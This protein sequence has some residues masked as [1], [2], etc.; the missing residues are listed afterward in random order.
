[1]LDKVRDGAQWI[2]ARLHDCQLQ[3][4]LIENEGHPVV[5][6]CS[7][8]PG[9]AS[10]VPTLLFYGHYDVQ[11]P[12]PLQKWTSPPFEPTIRGQSIYAR[13]ASDDNGQVCCFLEAVSA[14]MRV[15]G[16]LPCRV[17]VLIEGEEECGSIHL[18]RVIEAHKQE[19]KA[20]IVL[21]SDTT[22]WNRD[23]VAITYGLRGLLYFD[24]Q[25]HN[26]KRDLHSGMFGGILANPAT[27]LTQVLGQLS[28]AQYRITIPH[29]YDDVLEV[30]ETERR[31]WSR[32]GFDE[33]HDCLSTIGV[34]T[35]FGEAGYTTLERK[36]TRPTC[37]ICGLYG[38]YGGSGA[39]TVIPSFAGAKV[40][41]R[42]AGKQDPVKISGDFEHWLRSHGVRGCRWQI[43]QLGAADPVL[44][45]DDSPYMDAAKKAV[46]QTSGKP[47]VLVHD[48]ATIP[49]VADFKK[50]LG[51]DSLLIGFGQTDDCIHSP[52]E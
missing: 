27:I 21:I 22:M 29:F 31:N 18:R 5:L 49:V 32:L 1:M 19:L 25:L 52:N 38:G 9:P 13:G 12:D 26:A 16:K 24:I 30:T 46:E 17:M 40:S 35:P 4:Q 23:T 6:G 47:A 20:D 48:G 43:E 50:I 7:P 39:K 33:M 28:D 36:W 51:I 11:P 44:V 14:W 37:D 42:L 2:A 8:P 10:G 41:F 34:V 45:A 3:T 15:T